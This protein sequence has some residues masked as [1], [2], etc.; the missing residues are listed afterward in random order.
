[1][2]AVQPRI[3]YTSVVRLFQQNAYVAVTGET[4]IFAQCEDSFSIKRNISAY[5][6]DYDH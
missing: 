4:V 2:L 1:L 6:A 3:D 5:F